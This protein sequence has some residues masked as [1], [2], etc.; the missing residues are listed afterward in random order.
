MAKLSK[1][2]L[3]NRDGSLNID[4][5]NKGIPFLDLYHD[6]LR[7][8][9]GVFTLLW[10]FTF[11]F[12]NAFYGFL[13]FILPHSEFDGFKFES[14]IHHYFEC[15][16]FS[17]QTFGTIGYGKV[18]PVGFAANLVMTFECYTSLF[19][20]A[21]MTGLIFARFSKPNAKIIFSNEAVIKTFN[22]IPYLMF[23][24]ANSRQN[25][26]T[27]ANVKVTAIMDDATTG[28][29]EFHDLKLERDFSP[30]FALSWTIGHDI[31]ETS[32]LY[33]LTHDE[34]VERNMEL[35]V[36]VRGV[37]TVLSQTL[38]AKHSYLPSE[39]L[40]EHNFE[41]VIKRNENGNLELNL[42]KFHHTFSELKL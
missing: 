7:T 3:I 41:N 14:G 1:Y 12:I 18:S 40:R 30:I 15:F 26:I 25:T 4:A 31:D 42:E 19:V 28:F 33:N 27:D 34:L 23:R 37:D 36:T 38:Y 20:I 8:K 5:K 21:V 9:W 32:V 6:L 39:I 13:Y 17:V 24:I 29:R 2:R 11:L 10:L 16:F 22:G 35:I